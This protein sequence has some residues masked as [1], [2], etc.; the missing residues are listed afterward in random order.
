MAKCNLGEVKLETMLASSFVTTAHVLLGSL[1][2][3]R[4]SRLYRTH[5]PEIHCAILRLYN[6]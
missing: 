5:V 1:V 3:G 6:Y 4:A 2:S